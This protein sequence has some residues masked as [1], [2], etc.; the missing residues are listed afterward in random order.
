MVG[1]LVQYGY[2]LRYGRLWGYGKSIG[3]AQVP[4]QCHW[5]QYNFIPPSLHNYCE[6]FLK[7]ALILLDR[8]Q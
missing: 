5:A 3:A 7:L 8:K 4:M 2:E 1:V 6:K